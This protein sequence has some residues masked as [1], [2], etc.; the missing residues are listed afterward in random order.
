VLYYKDVGMQ[1]TSSAGSL[2]TRR[3]TNAE[4][5]IRCE[6]VQTDGEFNPT[7]LSTYTLY[8]RG[9]AT[10]AVQ[11]YLRA[12]SAIGPYSAYYI[13]MRYDAIMA[14]WLVIIPTHKA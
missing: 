5:G 6:F 7:G 3:G 13:M 12:V 4:R 1:I 9:C 2:D 14:Q 11:F 8:I 10:Q